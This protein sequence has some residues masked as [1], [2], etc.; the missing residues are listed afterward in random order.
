MS[1]PFIAHKPTNA[2]RKPKY[3]PTAAPEYVTT[4]RISQ[5]QPIG[6]RHSSVGFV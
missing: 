3:L 2:V 6:G 5:Q 4:H 1:W